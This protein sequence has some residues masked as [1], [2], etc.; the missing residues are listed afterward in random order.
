M[1]VLFTNL[2]S[3]LKL[4]GFFNNYDQFGLNEIFMIGFN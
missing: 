1:F 3:K 4:T 2:N